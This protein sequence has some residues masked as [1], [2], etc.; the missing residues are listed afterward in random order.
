MKLRL[1]PILVAAV[2]L[3]AVAPA[4]H[5]ASAAWDPQ[6]VTALARDLEV[7]TRQL[8]DTFEKLPPL[9]K[10]SSHTRAYFRLKQEARHMKRESHWL[11]RALERGHEQEEA[12]PGYESV[13]TAMRG[14]RQDAREV[15]TNAEFQTKADRVSAILDSLAPFFGGSSAPASP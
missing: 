10:G 2:G 6:K 14:A 4:G 9:E 3:L 15:Q 7:A 13:V 11:A 12:L 8:Y 5:A 1:A